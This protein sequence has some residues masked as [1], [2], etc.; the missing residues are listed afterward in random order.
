MRRLTKAAN[1]TAPAGT[2]RQGR[3]R[4]AAPRVAG[5]KA[6]PKSAKSA[7]KASSRKA[8]GSYILSAPKG[9]RTLSHRRIKQ[10]VER[11]FQERDYA[12]G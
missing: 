10:A 6:A 9:P 4:L 11:V 5:A 8:A 12:N 1:R 7:A 2:K 3:K